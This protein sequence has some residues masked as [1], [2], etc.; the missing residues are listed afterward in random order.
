V[1]DIKRSTI[2]WQGSGLDF[3]AQTAG[4]YSF[5]M[6]APSDADGATPMEYLLAG[7]AGC[8]AMDVVSILQKKRQKVHGFEVRIEG[9]QANSDPHV[10]THVNV[11]YVVRGE[12]VDP[13]ALERA[14]ELSQTKYCSAQAMFVRAGVE[15]TSTYTIEEMAPAAG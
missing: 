8:T 2:V 6:H 13:A 9:T 4:G 11:T 5:A 12:Q 10:F 3:R 14:I 7:V 15:I 1:A